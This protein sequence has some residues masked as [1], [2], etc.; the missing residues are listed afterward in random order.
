[1]KLSPFKL[2]LG[3]ALFPLILSTQAHAAQ[4]KVVALRGGG[5]AKTQA[6][7]AVN[8]RGKAKAGI[9][10]NGRFISARKLKRK[11]GKKARGALKQAKA[12][13]K[14]ISGNAVKGGGKSAAK[15]GQ[16]PGGSAPLLAQW[17]SQMVE[18]GKELCRSLQDSAYSADEKLLATYYD[19]EWV[20]YQIADYTGD[21]SWIDCAQAAEAVY[22][23]GY[24]TPGNGA[25]PGYWNFT[26]G[27][28]EDYMRTG[29]EASRKA[30][31]QLA[32]NAAFA[33]AGTPLSSTESAD[34]SRETAYAI[35]AYL[36]AELVG[37]PRNPRLSQLLEQAFGHMNQWFEAKS[38]PYVRPFMAALTSQALISYHEQ[39]GDQR[40]LPAVKKAADWLWSNTWLPESEAFMYTDRQVESGGQEASP[41]LNLLVAPVYAWVY[42]QTGDQ[43]YRD[44][45]DQIFAG[46]VKAAFLRG[47][48]FNQNYRWSFAYLKWR[49]EAPL[50]K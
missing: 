43:S 32:S 21:N 8:K 36:N 31:V 10:K 48:Q 23:D 4:R 6:A 26:H 5:K 40:V 44:R 29:D 1:M 49:N 27:L 22:R 28:L 2:I 11:A 34:Q 25:I 45:A 9:R 24:V 46:G 20:F 3:G 50:S 33:S 17:Q 16:T 14:N 35:M 41:D 18:H 37:E 47:K 7:C 42:H 12:G 19:A 39:H 30:L 15:G 38:A 13:C